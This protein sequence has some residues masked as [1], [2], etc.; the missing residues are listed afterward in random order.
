MERI[1]G[2]KKEN[3]YFFLTL[4]PNLMKLR[5]EAVD[6]DDDGDGDDHEKQYGI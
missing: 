6:D 1:L 4:S 5:V 3:Q 2:T